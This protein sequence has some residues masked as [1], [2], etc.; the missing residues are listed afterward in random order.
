M[1]RLRDGTSS[2]VLAPSDLAALLD[3]FIKRDRRSVNQVAH[4]AALDTGYVWRL[5]NGQRKKPSRDVLIRLG[6]ALRLEVEE[7]DQLLTAAD[8]I[9]LSFRQS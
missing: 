7:V 6:F 3:G 8:Y 1:T 2:T 4:E 9:P 5:K